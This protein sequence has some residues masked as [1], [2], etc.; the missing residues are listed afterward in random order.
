MAPCADWPIDTT[1]CDDW[2]AFTPEIQA[3]ATTWATHILWALTGR[4]FGPCPVNLRPCR[5]RCGF[6][7]GYATFP[8]NAAQASGAGTPWVYPWIDNGIWRN[9]GCAAVCSCRASQEILLP[10]PVASVTEV[11]IDGAILDPSAYRLD[12]GS[13]LVRI[14]GD[15]WPECQDMDLANDAVGAFTVTYQRGTEVPAAGLMAAGELACQYAKA[16]TG[17]GDCQLPAQL[18]SLSRNGVQV[19]VADPSE[20]LENGLT[21]LANVDLWIRSVN[22]SRKAQRSRV[23]SPDLNQ[24]RFTA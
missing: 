1:C 16:C 23:L 15:A 9:C 3:Q 14:D 2:A 13:I 24:P 8:V 12:N 6:R 5:S 11:M 18:A 19:E 17:S 20:F 4:Q 10:G 7:A 22:P 21:G